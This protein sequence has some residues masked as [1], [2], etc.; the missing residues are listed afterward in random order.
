ML[1]FYWR[2]ARLGV[3]L[4]GLALASVSTL[5]LIAGST[6]PGPSHDNASRGSA[7]TRSGGQIKRAVPYPVNMASIR[8]GMKLMNAAVAACRTVSYT[9]VQV[10]AW[11]GTGLSTAYLIGVWHQSGEP[12]VADNAGGSDSDGVP[13]TIARPG[14]A[15]SDHAAAGVLSVSS[16]MLKLLHA[17]YLIE[18][19]GRGAADG[20]PAQ[21]VTVRRRD[22]SMAAQY[23]LDH[24]T[25]LPLRREMFNSSGQ[26]VN[27]GAFIDL[28]FRPHALSPLPGRVTRAWRPQSA[29][30]DLPRLR[31]QGWPVPVTL[32]G[33]MTLVGVSRTV[34]SAGAVV[35]ASY[36]DGLSVVSVFM[37][38]GELAR[39]LPGW[40]QARVHGALVYSSD[41]DQRSLAWSAH[42]VVYTVIS[43]A[44]QGTVDLIVSQLPHDRDAGFWQR[45]GR[46][47]H[48]MG[49]WFDPFG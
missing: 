20:R 25:G 1:W 40:H 30:S 14:A 11:W 32:A 45:V 28:D 5:V 10:V 47:L 3:L 7:A 8:R 31:R 33:K 49:S 43:D 16:W 18:Y 36:S 21:V 2:R 9:G 29:K 46:G 26:L 27:E 6:G 44:P 13:G 24:R 19:A 38:R 48:R 15:A 22:G 42:D 23:W 17:N 39:A 41:P 34:T 37:Q 35:D 4:A 12:E